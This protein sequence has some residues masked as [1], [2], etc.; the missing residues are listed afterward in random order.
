MLKD[1]SNAREVDGFKVGDRVFVNGVKV[2]IL[3]F[4]KDGKK[5]TGER[6][7]PVKPGEQSIITA[8]LVDCKGLTEAKYFDVP[9]D[10]DSDSDRA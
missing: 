10:N 4:S 3:Y 8:K 1:Y 6:C 9:L 7:G 5:M 2:E